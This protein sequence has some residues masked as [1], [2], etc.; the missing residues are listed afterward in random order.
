VRSSASQAVKA[1]SVLLNRATHLI[2][3]T[4]RHQ[5]ASS[6]RP[7]LGKVNDADDD[8]HLISLRFRSLQ[9]YQ[10]FLKGHGEEAEKD[11]HGTAYLL[12]SLAV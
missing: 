7:I 8:E 1:P 9:L 11:A 5:T 6:S 3:T 10:A 12:R 4:F 2:P